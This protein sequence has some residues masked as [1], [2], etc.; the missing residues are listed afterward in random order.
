MKIQPEKLLQM[1]DSFSYMRSKHSRLMVLC[2]RWI[3]FHALQCTAQHKNPSVS[4]DCRQDMDPLHIAAAVT[5]H[6]GTYESKLAA[7]V[8]QYIRTL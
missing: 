4:M 2:D 1:S 7:L 8:N 3:K 5:H 6:L